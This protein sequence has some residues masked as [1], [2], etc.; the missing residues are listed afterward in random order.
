MWNT[1]KG[2]FQK[3]N[4]ADSIKNTQLKS[5]TYNRIHLGERLLKVINLNCDVVLTV[6]NL[7]VIRF[8]GPNDRAKKC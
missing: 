6:W 8:T 2:N 1:R 7:I 4:A 5:I 3:K